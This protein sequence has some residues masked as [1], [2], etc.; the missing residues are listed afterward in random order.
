MALA[1]HADLLAAIGTEHVAHV[2][3][4]TKHGDLHHIRHVSCLLDDHGNQLLRAG[5]NDDTVKRDGLEHGQRNVA[6]SG[7]AVDE[8]VVKVSPDG[9]RPELL[10]SARDDRASPD[11]GS[12]LVVQH[13]VDRHDLNACG[14]CGRQHAVSVALDGLV[15][16]KRLGDRRAGDIGIQDTDAIALALHQHGKHRGYKRFT[17]AALAADDTDDMLD[18]RRGM[19]RFIHA[20]L[21]SGGAVCRAGGTIVGTFGHF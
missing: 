13:Q 5:N 14:G 4:Q 21:V 3:N 20:L 11:N 12:G 7:R 15:Q 18:R 9:L 16:A 19:G 10:D 6:R 17:N 2:L 8:Q 1:E